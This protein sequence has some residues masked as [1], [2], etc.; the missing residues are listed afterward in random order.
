M[1]VDR[2]RLPGQPDQR[3]DRVAAIGGDVEDVLPVALGVGLALRRFEEARTAQER[4]EH[5]ADT[6]GQPLFVLLP[7]QGS[8]DPA[9][10]VTENRVRL[11][12][13]LR[14]HGS[15]SPRLDPVEPR[16]SLGRR[17]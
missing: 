5:L 10:Q 8:I 2:S 4:T 9:D 11:L 16:A 14:L 3:D 7:C 17:S 1:V 15:S 13:R 12:V 6:L